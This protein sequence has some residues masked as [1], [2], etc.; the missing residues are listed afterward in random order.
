[1]HRRS[2]VALALFPNNVPERFPTIVET[3]DDP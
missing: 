1:M 3:T 2:L